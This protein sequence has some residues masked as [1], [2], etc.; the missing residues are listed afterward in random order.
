MVLVLGCNCERSKDFVMYVQRQKLYQFLMGL[1]ESFSHTRSHILLLNPLPSVNQAYSMVVNDERQRSLASQ[2]SSG[3]FKSK[4]QGV[5]AGDAVAMYSRGGGQGNPRIKRKYNPNY[6]PNAFCD[7]CRFKGHYMKDCYRYREKFNRG[8]GHGPHTAHNVVTE[9]WCGA[10]SNQQGFYVPQ[11]QAPPSN[12][13][14]MP[15]QSSA[16]SNYQALAYANFQQQL[17]QFQRTEGL[18]L[19]QKLYGEIRQ[20]L[21]QSHNVAQSHSSSTSNANASHAANMTG[22]SSALFVSHDSQEWIIDSGAT[23]H[24][25]SNLN[26]LDK[27][28]LHKPEDLFTRK[29]KEIGKE[30]DG[31][32]YLI[33]SKLRLTKEQILGYGLTS[34]CNNDDNIILWH[35]KMGHAPA[36]VLQKL[37][38]TKLSSITFLINNCT[39]CP[40]ARQTRLPFSKSTTVSSKPFE[41]VHMDADVYILNRLPSTVL[42]NMSPY[43]KLVHK[44]PSLVHLRVLGCLSFAKVLN[45]HDKL[46][47]RSRTATHMG[48]SETQ[49]GYI[50]Y[51]MENKNFFVHRDVI[52]KEDVF[53]FLKITPSTTLFAPP[54]SVF[55]ESDAKI[56]RPTNNAQ[57]VENIDIFP[58]DKSVQ[59][60]ENQNATPEVVQPVHN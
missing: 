48:Y 13:M 20:L 42:N 22:N 60:P 26:L 28:T 23:D 50:L 18:N 3:L 56:Q 44:K 2:S 37:F 8:G 40:C 32:Y 33:R 53:P 30:G 17:A 6:N 12:M 43:E 59:V 15:A 27:N 25:T 7:N 54:I 11:V 14:M 31:L 19:S 57:V 5:C 51:D 35:K 47:S 58:T 16:D 4:S 41:L 52:F 1:N 49:K 45:Q 46:Q 36:T 9:Q 55:E 29:V 24:M 34:A 10:N 21:E 39:V 38:P